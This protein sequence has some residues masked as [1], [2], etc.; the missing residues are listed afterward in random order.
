MRNNDIRRYLIFL[1]KVITPFQDVV[2]YNTEKENSFTTFNLIKKH[3]GELFLDKIISKKIQFSDD[4][5]IPLLLV[6]PQAQRLGER[7]EQVTKRFFGK[8]GDNKLTR[9]I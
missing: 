4:T 2:I 8:M 7:R 9:N 3:Q 5:T 6:S 1:F